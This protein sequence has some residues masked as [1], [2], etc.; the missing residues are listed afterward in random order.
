MAELLERARPLVDA[1][2]LECLRRR[3]K[4]RELLGR[5]ADEP[6]N[7]IGTKLPAALGVVRIHAIEGPERR[8]DRVPH[9]LG[10]PPA[11][12]EVGLNVVQR[13]SAGGPLEAHRESHEV[14]YPFVTHCVACVII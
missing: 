8:P 4:L 3:L 14:L 9:A 1:G 11:D 12:G 10:G 5:N 6:A 7:H 2:A 13:Q